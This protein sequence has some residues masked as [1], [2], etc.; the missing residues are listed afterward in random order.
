MNEKRILI[1]GVGN[2][3]LSDEGVGV[4]AVNKLMKEYSFPPCVT[5][6]DGGTL[7]ISL[8]EYLLNCDY[9]IVIDALR[10]GHAPGSVY[11]LE[12]E[13][14]RKS[15]GMSDSMHQLDL[16]DTL[17]LCELAEG[18]KPDAVVFG[19]EPADMESLSP[20]LTA[21]GKA[22]L[23]K[24]CQVVLDELERLGLQAMPVSLS[25]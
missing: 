14:L 1:L 7:G 18:K 16:V 19:L 17:N 22:A 23:P 5:L 9:L 11:R 12:G 13:G 20:E 25:S 10:G 2:L 8:M 15:L 4:H 21:T 24:L 6:M 3:L